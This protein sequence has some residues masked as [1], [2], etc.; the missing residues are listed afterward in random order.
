MPVEGEGWGKER[1][2]LMPYYELGSLRKQPREKM[3]TRK[4][5]EDILYQIL[6]VL[7]QLHPAVAHR[8]L[9][10]ENILV[11]SR[12]TSISIRIVDFGL[13]KVAEG[14]ILKGNKGTSLYIAPKVGINSQNY[15]PSVELW[16]AGVIVLEYAY[17]LSE[18]PN[19]GNWCQDIVNHAQQMDGASDPLLKILQ[20]GMLK[21]EA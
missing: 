2:L 6:E 20:T 9:K 13:A 17:G 8:D 4:E 3:L 15:A 21:M 14:T 16:S 18:R 11:E 19:R 10:P 5:I 7:V 1:W 12:E